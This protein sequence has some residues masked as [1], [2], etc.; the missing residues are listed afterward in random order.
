[1]AV[2]LFKK[3]SRHRR[4]KERG[5][6]LDRTR[7]I[8]SK[9]HFRPPPVQMAKMPPEDDGMWVPIRAEMTSVVQRGN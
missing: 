3:L 2:R 9:G 7:C 6:A 1:M 4:W 8:H 5:S